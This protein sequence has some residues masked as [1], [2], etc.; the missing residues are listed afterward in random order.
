MVIFQKP[1]GSP[2]FQCRLYLFQ[3]AT[4]IAR[5]AAAGSRPSTSLARAP[6]RINRPT[7]VTDL[8]VVNS[9]W[10]AGAIRPF[11]RPHC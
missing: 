5:Q 8:W 6:N 11:R 9:L 7:I 10:L 1:S 2:R 3:P 4:V